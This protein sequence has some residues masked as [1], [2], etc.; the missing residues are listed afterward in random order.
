MSLQPQTAVA[1]EQK[2]ALSDRESKAAPF[3]KKVTRGTHLRKTL[4]LLK[5]RHRI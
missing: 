3:G 1:R 2:C 4:P 5:N